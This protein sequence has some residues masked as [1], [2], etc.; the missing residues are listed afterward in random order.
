MKAGFKNQ[1][2][3]G[4]KKELLKQLQVESQNNTMALR[5][6]QMMLKRMLEDS[7]NMGKDLGGVLGQ[8]TEYRYQ[9][10]A[11]VQALGLDPA[12][13]ADIANTQRLADFNTGADKA[14]V[15]ENLVHGDVV[16]EDSTVVLTSTTDD[17]EGE[18][19]RSRIKLADAGVPGLL[20]GFLGQ[21][22]GTVVDVELNG[23]VHHVE[24]LAIRNPLPALAAVPDA[25][26]ADTTQAPN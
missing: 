26:A 24:L 1:G 17:K 3:A 14:D 12:N 20:K 7:Q 18:I 25:S 16:T 11:L 8:L 13:I 4:S 23:K 19:F 22:V 15:T 6:T 2:D 21:P 10:S 9:L 5:M